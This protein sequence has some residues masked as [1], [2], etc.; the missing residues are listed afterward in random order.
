MNNTVL[1]Y[2]WILVLLSF[3]RYSCLP[4]AFSS[5]AFS[6]SCRSVGAFSR[7]PGFSSSL[8]TLDS[9]PSCR[10]L[11]VSQCP[12]PL[13]SL[14]HCHPLYQLHIQLSTAVQQVFPIHCCFNSR[15]L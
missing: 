15:S 9:C 3:S 10:P 14:S 7:I 13:F 8:G 6:Y 2:S 11:A 12:L 1:S 4:L 5:P